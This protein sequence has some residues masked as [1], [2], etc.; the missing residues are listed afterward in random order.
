MEPESQT[1]S[2]STHSSFSTTPAC[3]M[4]LPCCS[5]TLLTRQLLGWTMLPAEWHLP[6]RG[7]GTMLCHWIN[8]PYDRHTE[9]LNMLRAQGIWLSVT[10][11][12]SSMQ[13]A[14]VMIR[15]KREPSLYARQICIWQPVSKLL[16]QPELLLSPL[17]FLFSLKAQD[18]TTKSRTLRWDYMLDFTAVWTWI[19]I[20][21]NTQ[22]VFN[23]ATDNFCHDK[24][25]EN[26]SRLQRSVLSYKTLN[27]HLRETD[28][29][30]WHLLL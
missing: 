16:L 10:W 12:I 11:D 3:E 24:C 25:S 29:Y 23:P 17:L 15:E 22:D 2:W 28:S 13:A 9:H 18:T 21:A 20:A 30:V 1:H 27:A 6:A 8:L 19:N 7:T 5:H 26:E 4:S 14:S